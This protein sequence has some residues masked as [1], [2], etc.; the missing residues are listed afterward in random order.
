MTDQS[1][2]A[3]V[4]R[5][6]V[7]RSVAVGGMALPLLAACGGNDNGSTGTPAGGDSTTSGSTSGGGS[8]SG[9][10]SSGGLVKAADVPV[11]GGT[12]IADAQVVVVQPT[13]G[14]FKA[15]SA[16]CTHQ[17]CPVNKVEGGQI[18]CPCHNSH[19][20]IKDGSVVS[21]PAPKPLASVKIKVA[22]GEIT[23]A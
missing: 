5:R 12:I 20:S 3:E 17:G 13:K 2:P 15:Y 7:V 11:G 6:S 18:V 10:G 16:I 23:K 22:G 9:S 21:G 19:Y 14:D 4:T 1:V 8:G